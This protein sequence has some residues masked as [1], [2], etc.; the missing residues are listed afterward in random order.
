[1]GWRLISFEGRPGFALAVSVACTGGA[2]LFQ[3]LFASAAG[4]ITPPFLSFFPAIV[5]SARFGG[6]ASGW[7]TLSASALL[8]GHFLLAPDAGIQHLDLPRLLILC[9]FL[10]SGAVIVII[11]SAYRRTLDA[12]ERARQALQSTETRLRLAHEAAKIGTWEYVIKDDR[13]FWS[14]EMFRLFDLDPSDTAPTLAEWRSHVQLNGRPDDYYSLRRDLRKSGQTLDRELLI[15]TYKG[16]SRWLLGRSLA[17]GKQG[18]PPTEFIGV[19]IDITE[20]KMSEERERLLAHELDHRA[21]NMLAMVQSVVQLTRSEK[22]SEFREAVIGRIQSLARSHSLLAA[23]RWEGADLIQLIRD[24]LEPFMSGEHAE[25]KASGPRVK[26]QPAAAQTLALLV[27]ELATNAVKYGAL[28]TEAGRLT[29][30]WH[31]ASAGKP[32]DL[33]LTW[34]EMGGPAVKIPKIRGFGSRLIVTSVE[35]QLNGKVAMNWLPDGLYC[36]VTIPAEHLLAASETE[37]VEEQSVPHELSDRPIAGGGGRR[38]LLVEDETLIAMQ[39]E[40]TLSHAGYTVIGPVTRLSDA[41]ETIANNILDGAIL[42]I[43]LN[44][45]RSFAIADLL[46]SRRVPFMFCTGFAAASVLPDRFRGIPVIVKPFSA[47]NLLARLEQTLARGPAGLRR[48][49]GLALEAD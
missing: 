31:F 41:P 7:L 28:S 43:N 8:A 14:P 29:I 20:Q 1:M 48:T 12:A 42:D 2:F 17:V 10:I 38:I 26:L 15:Q 40:Q 25:I 27:H 49:T 44:G 3:K 35:R 4:A 13:L 47:T 19:S 45:E 36:E 34:T 24:E 9:L 33:H 21:K 11:A 30:Y 18:E 32:G 6:T 23:S 5:V 22:L 16:K 46:L 37:T 39:A